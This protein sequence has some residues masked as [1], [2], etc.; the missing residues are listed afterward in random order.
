MSGLIDPN[1]DNPK[2]QE[3]KELPLYQHAGHSYVTGRPDAD[4]WYD[5]IHGSEEAFGEIYE[6]NFEILVRLGKQF[7]LDKEVI[8]DA[9]QDFFIDL[10]ERRANLSGINCIRPY[11][12]KSFRRRL[13]DLK[14]RNEKRKSQL[15]HFMNLQFTVIPSSEKVIA[16]REIESEKSIKLTQSIKKLSNNQREA[17]YYLYFEDMSYKEI[18]QVMGMKYVRSVRNLVYKALDQ[19]KKVYLQ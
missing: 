9:I 18:Q 17:I 14:K 13:L 19:L 8:R 15:E 16:D 11:L 1:V 6:S 12:L 4:V 7:S 2:K 3:G 5:F 10:R